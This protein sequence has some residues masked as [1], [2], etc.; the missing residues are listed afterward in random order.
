MIIHGIVEIFH[1]TNLVLRSLSHTEPL[2]T[3]VFAKFQYSLLCVYINMMC[4]L[5]LTGTTL[6]FLFKKSFF[7]LNFIGISE[8]SKI[9]NV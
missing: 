2:N 1:R 5:N 3:S 6:V 8:L 4:R 7:F 9:K